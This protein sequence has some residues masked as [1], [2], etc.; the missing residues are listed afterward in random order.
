[1]SLQPNEKH[2]N[3]NDSDDE[4]DEDFVP[5]DLEPEKDTTEN[6]GKTIT[7]RT[8]TY[9]PKSPTIE[10]ESLKPDDK[11][12]ADDL[13]ADFMNDVGPSKKV[14][15]TVSSPPIK[16]NIS[17]KST[18]D[19][20]CN[21]TSSKTG[22]IRKSLDIFGDE[23]VSPKITIQSKSCIDTLVPKSEP[24]S[25]K[26]SDKLTS[27]LAKINKEPKIGTLEKSLLDWNEFKQSEG[28]EEDLEIQTKSKNSYLDKKAFLER[29]DIR[30]YEIERDLRNQKKLK[31]F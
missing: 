15:K 11:K 5:K 25:V 14:A 13:W 21:I 24:R 12:K 23:V 8:R 31:K 4:S 6:K 10:I 26:S 16:S 18:N 27:I 28:I 22:N 3:E 29:S 2:L 1:M 17:G 30:E 9:R 20:K 7:T 19:S